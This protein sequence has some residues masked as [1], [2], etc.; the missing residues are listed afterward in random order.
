MPTK[1]GD[2]TPCTPHNYDIGFNLINSREVLLDP[3]PNKSLLKVAM[4]G[5]L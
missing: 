1:P 4:K 3:N 2:N 5:G